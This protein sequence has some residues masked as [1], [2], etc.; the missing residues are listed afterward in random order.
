MHVHRVLIHQRLTG[1]SVR[2]TELMTNRSGDMRCTMNYT[3]MSK[4]GLSDL[5]D[6]VEGNITGEEELPEI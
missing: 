3:A 6:E 5:G 2:L 4:R 1:F